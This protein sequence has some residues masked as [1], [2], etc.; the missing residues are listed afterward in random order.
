[1][2]DEFKE[3]KN[4][5]NEQDIDEQVAESYY[6]ENEAWGDISVSKGYGPYRVSVTCSKCSFWYTAGNITKPCPQCQHQTYPSC[7]TN[8]CNAWPHEGEVYCTNHR[9]NASSSSSSSSSSSNYTQYTYTPPP[10]YY[11][12]NGCGSVVSYSGSYCYQ[13]SNQCSSC[14][15]RI[16]S[17]QSYCSSHR[18][19]CHGCGASVSSSNSYCS[20]TACQKVQQNQ[21]TINSLQGQTSN[22]QTRLNTETTARQTAE[23]Q[24]QTEQNAHTTTRAQRDTYAASLNDDIGFATNDADWR[25]K[26]QAKLNGKK[27]SDITTNLDDVLTKASRTT[28]AETERNNMEGELNQKNT[29]ITNAQTH[30]QVADLTNLPNMNG[31]TLDQV[32]AKAARTV[33]AETVITNAR[34]HLGIADLANLPNMNNQTLQQALDKI[35]NAQNNL[36]IN[37][38]NDLPALLNGE[39]L[40]NLLNRPTQQQLQDEQTARQNTERQRDARPNTTINDYNNLVRE[41]NNWTNQFTNQAPQ[42]VNNRLNTAEGRVQQAENFGLTQWDDLD[43]QTERQTLDVLLARP[44]QDDLNGRAEIT[45]DELTNLRNERDRLEREKNEA[46]EEAR[47]L[48]EQNNQPLNQEELTQFQQLNRRLEARIQTLYEHLTNFEAMQPGE[49]VQI[50]REYLGIL[51][52]N[53]RNGLNEDLHEALDGLLEA[54]ETLAR[55]DNHLAQRLLNISKRNLLSNRQLTEQQIDELF[56]ARR[57]LTRLEREQ[58]GQENQEQQANIQ[59]CHHQEEII[60]R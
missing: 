25:D 53:A 8:G 39:N 19:S 52:N 21:N 22:L 40:T 44:T 23:R 56:Q 6:L 35:T 43:N 32:L 1:M 17:G 37:N 51:I 28:T 15:T 26:L 47:R 27:V 55:G 50:Q 30:L 3:N 2:K 31:D 11:C 9:S 54:Q 10:T 57:K 34:T 13:H 14:S 46:R 12:A 24:L 49:M 38:L 29:I 48:R 42:G 20:A 36:G 60:R 41:R 5:K 33:A 18:P 58:Q 45:P 4:T 7:Q 16:S 59:V